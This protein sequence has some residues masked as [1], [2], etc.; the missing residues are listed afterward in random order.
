[1]AAILS[2]ETS[3]FPAPADLN[4]TK[5]FQ[6]LSGS[7]SDPIV[8]AI[9]V[10]TTQ[11]NNKLDLIIADMASQNAAVLL[12]L[13]NLKTSVDAVKTSVDLVKT[14]VNLTTAEVLNQGTLIV[15]A[16]NA[17]P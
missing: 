1:M 17:H 2:I 9:A 4:T 3:T 12:A 8:T 7:P 6:Y 5:S 10:Q 11:I 13:S 14:A 16:I 15:A